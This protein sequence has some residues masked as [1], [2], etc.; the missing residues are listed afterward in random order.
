MKHLL[1]GVAMAAAL[2]AIAVP[3]WAQTSTTPMTSPASPPTIVLAQGAT[4]R[5]TEQRTPTRTFMHEQV[6]NP[7]A[8]PSNAAPAAEGR[9][10]NTRRYLHHVVHHR[11]AMSGQSEAEQLNAQELQRIQSGAQP[12]PPPMPMTPG[13]NSPTSGSAGPFAPSR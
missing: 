6:T 13:G 4:G 10:M 11:R 12:T 8:S 3:V 9:R 2:I 5:T 7:T 1:T